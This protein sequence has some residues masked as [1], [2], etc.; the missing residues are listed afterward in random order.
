ME[1][2][3]W[4][5]NIAVILFALNLSSLV[6]L[7]VG[8]L[9]HANYYYKFYEI[10]DEVGIFLHS[11]FTAILGFFGIIGY[12]LDDRMRSPSLFDAIITING[13][14]GVAIIVIVVLGYLYGYIMSIHQYFGAKRGR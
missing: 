9:T 7:S 14:Y 11:L 4:L 2:P 13:L 5:H 1:I 10:V 8:W 3:I 12:F 6:V